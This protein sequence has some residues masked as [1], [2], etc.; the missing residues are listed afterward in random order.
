[1]WGGDRRS[2]MSS[3][4]PDCGEDCL[5]FLGEETPRFDRNACFRSAERGHSECLRYAHEN[6]CP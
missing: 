2:P 3:A 4:R 5:E 6:G 1:M